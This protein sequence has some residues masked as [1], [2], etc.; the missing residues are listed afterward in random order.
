MKYRKLVKLCTNGH[1]R[2]I[3]ENNR[4]KTR[5]NEGRP[6]LGGLEFWGKELH[7]IRLL[8]AYALL[9]LI[10]FCSISLTTKVEQGSTIR[11]SLTLGRIIDNSVQE[12]LGQT[13]RA[14]WQRSQQGRRRDLFSMK[15]ADMHRE[16]NF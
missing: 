7:L 8:V 16:G 3:E 6:Y 11:S 2:D 5:K 14:C 13:R 9:Y 10:R 1:A 15:A 4:D 12:R